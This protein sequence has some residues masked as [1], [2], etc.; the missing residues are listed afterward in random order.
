[1]PQ[2]TPLTHDEIVAFRGKRGRHDV[3]DLTPFTDFLR[4]I[5]AGEGGE[6]TLTPEEKRRTVKRHMN[7]AAQ[8]LNVTINWRRSDHQVMRFAVVT[9]AALLAAS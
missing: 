9:N 5:P 8:N 6:I 7:T 1:M 3:V 4:E 2:F